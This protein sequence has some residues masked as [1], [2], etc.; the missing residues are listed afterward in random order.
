[1]RPI[2]THTALIVRALLATLFMAARAEAQTEADVV[3]G[4]V[5]DDS[6]RA[7]AGATVMIT[8]GPDRLT[9]QTTTDSTG[10]FSSRFEQGTGDY[11]VYVNATGFKAERRRVQRQGAERELVANFTLAR[12]L[13]VLAAVRVTALRPER[14]SNQVRPTDPEPG[15]NDRWNEG[16]QGQIPPM[17]AGD[18]NATAGT[19]SNVTMTPGGASILGSASESNLTT[20]N[21]MGLASGSIPRA[22]IT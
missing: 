6:A 14:A 18:L 7:V 11:L 4:R 16:V 2:R 1:M 10:A 12:D 15:S 3:R 22:A 20:L 21:G 19:M 17:V 5:I 9:Q 8:R 13:T